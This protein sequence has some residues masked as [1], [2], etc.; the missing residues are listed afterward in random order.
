MLH[1]SIRSSGILCSVSAWAKKN[2]RYPLCILYTSPPISLFFEKSGVTI[3]EGAKPLPITAGVSCF[4][5]TMNGG[6]AMTIYEI[7]KAAISVKQAAKH[8]GL[9]VNRNGM[10]CCQMC[11][12]DRDSSPL[13]L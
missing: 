11:I 3:V 8:Y 4:L 7:I 2:G 5:N 1:T 6:F 10:A 9:N 13:F 12:R